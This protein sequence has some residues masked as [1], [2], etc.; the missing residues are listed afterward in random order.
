MYDRL[1]GC[2]AYIFVRSDWL[3][4]SWM[5]PMSGLSV[6]Y[7]LMPDKFVRRKQGPLPMTR[8]NPL[9]GC[10]LLFRFVG[11]THPEIQT[12]IAGRITGYA[13]SR[14]SEHPAGWR[15]DWDFDPNRPFEQGHFDFGAQHRLIQTQWYQSTQV[16]SL[17]FELR[18]D[19]KFG[20]RIL[21]IDL[22][23]NKN[24]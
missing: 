10:K 2:N 5:E 13:K 7:R 11:E 19:W 3:L 14:D 8:T 22:N 17:P 12:Q 6:F 23:P 16:F 20:F 1:T 15:L 24:D 18:F 4:Y 9:S 21:T